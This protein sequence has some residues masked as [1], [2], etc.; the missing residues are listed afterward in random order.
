[1]QEPMYDMSVPLII[2]MLNNL[3]NILSKAE[4]FSTRRKIE[5]HVL[6]ESR[7]IADMFPLS[8]QIQIAT[9]MTRKGVARLAKKNPPSY[10]DNEKTIKQLQNRIDKTINFLKKIKP[11]QMNGSDKD[12]IKFSI[13]S[14]SFYFKSGED[15]LKSWIL[16]HFFFHITT[17]YNILRMN[18]INIGKLDYTGKF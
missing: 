1:M 10:K 14:N 7:L 2:K 3:S 18:G 17:T 6:L 15:Y 11:Q 12:E 13:R 9:D 4:K 8:K 16:P 5:D